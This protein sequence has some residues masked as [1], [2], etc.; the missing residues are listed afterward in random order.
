MQITTN[1]RHHEDQIKDS[2]KNYEAAIAENERQRLKLEVI[3]F[4][5][6]PDD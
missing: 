5:F 6:Y 3:S 2:Q 4:P 1:I